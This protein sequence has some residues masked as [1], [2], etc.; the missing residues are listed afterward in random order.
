MPPKSRPASL[1]ALLAASC[2]GLAVA[3][4]S[5]D[6]V[7]LNGGVFDAVGIG[8]NSAKKTGTPKLA[9][10]APLVVPPSMDRLPTP[11]EGQEPPAQIAGINDPDAVKSKSR[12]ELEQQQAEYCRKNYDDARMR[13]EE[14]DMVAGPLGPCR[15]S[16]LTAIQKWNGAED[17]AAGQ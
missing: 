11:G 8:A 6:D 12:E 16:V 10:R 4:C 3:G 15:K 7:E 2:I 17:E 9:E 13:G 1:L 5:A 14:A